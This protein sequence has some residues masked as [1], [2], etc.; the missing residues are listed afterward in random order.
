MKLLDIL[1]EPWAITPAKKK[2]LDEIY[3]AHLRGEKIDLSAIEA[4]NGGPLNNQQHA[5]YELVDGV[6]IIEI[7]GVMAKKMNL[8]AKISG[9]SSTQ[10][11]SDEVNKA[12][13]DPAVHSILLVIDSPGGAVD[14]IQELV[15]AIRSASAAK[16]TAAVGDLMASAAYWAASAAG[17]VFLSNSLAM[18]GSI[19]VVATHVDVSGAEAKAGI[20]TTEITAGK[21]KRIAT[22][23]APLTESGA[24]SIQDKVDYIYGIMLTDVANHRGVASTQDV[25]DQMADGQMFIGQ[26]AVDAGLVD[27]ISTVSDVL[28]MLGAGDIPLRSSTD[29]SGAVPP[30]LSAKRTHAHAQGGVPSAS[31]TQTE[32]IM[33]QEDVTAE[34]AKPF[35][36]AAVAASTSAFD[37]TK[38]ALREEGA[39]A[40]RKRIQD[41]RAQTMPGHEALIET[42]AFDGKTTGE[43]AAVQ[44]LAAEKALNATKAKELKEDA[45]KAAPHAAETPEAIEAAEAAAAK[46][47]DPIAIAA[48]AKTYQAEQKKL[49]NIVDAVD[50]VAHVT[51]Q[52]AQ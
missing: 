12:A 51:A 29:A 41:V 16:P 42:L 24:K 22:A 7:N 20:K 8:F 5:D 13:A 28:A 45:G 33:K 3:A 49:G 48:K 43:Q 30:T 44:V 21:Y 26:Q 4:A 18:A 9:G 38:P 25:H 6:A 2:E 14:G 23:H 52:E 36:E 46:K 37:A 35:V 34:N 40:E 17:K 31:T 39:A 50:A 10:M 32:T 15:S 19:G 47:L 1:T 27:G 11:L